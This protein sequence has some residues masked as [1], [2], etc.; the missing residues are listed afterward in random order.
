MSGID[1]MLGE[2]VPTVVSGM[3]MATDGQQISGGSVNFR[4]AGAAT[5]RRTDGGT[6]LRPDGTFRLQM[7]PGEYLFEVNAQPPRLPNQPFVPGTGAVRLDARQRGRRRGGRR[8]HPDRQRRDGVGPDRVRGQ[9]AA[10][11]DPVNPRRV[12]MFNP[13]GPGCRAGMATIAPDWTFKVEGLGG[14]APRSP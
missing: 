7:P 13:D 14:A 3:V 2:G 1:I 8:H 9:D 5:S 6:G 10:A 12:P 4:M 11:G